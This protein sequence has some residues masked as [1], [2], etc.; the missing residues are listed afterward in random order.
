MGTC[1]TCW[2]VEGRLGPVLDNCAWIQEIVALKVLPT[3]ALCGLVVFFLVARLDVQLA[4]EGLGK[5]AYEVSFIQL[6]RWSALPP[7]RDHLA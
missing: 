7:L 5:R 4:R 6:R 2:T 3:F 1:R